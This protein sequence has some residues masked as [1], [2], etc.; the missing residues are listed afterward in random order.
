MRSDLLRNYKNIDAEDE[1]IVIN[2]KL[3]K[4]FR[5]QLEKIFK[6]L[7]ESGERNNNAL[8]M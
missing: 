1:G 7:N 5:Q 4:Y 6:G 8:S 2:P 3:G